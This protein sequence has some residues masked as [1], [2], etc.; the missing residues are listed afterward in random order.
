MLFWFTPNS[1]DDVSSQ[2]SC[3]LFFK[4]LILITCC[5]AV[6]ASKSKQDFQ[7]TFNFMSYGFLVNGPVLHYTYS[8]LI[9]LFAPGNSIGSV[10][11]KLLFTQTAFSLVSI[12]SF[13]I[14]TSQCEGKS[15]QG[16]KDEL[17]QKLL[18]TFKTNL[19][20]WPLL[21]LI[22]FTMVPAPLQVFYVNFMQIWWNAYLSFMKFSDKDH[23]SEASLE[24]SKSSLEIVAS[25]Q[26]NSEAHVRKI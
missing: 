2:S 23:L 26:I 10:A 21:Q 7:R 1:S 24:L 15:L 25:T 6:D 4:Y 20:V 14:F 5:T 13:F 9:P 19:K 3:S 8:K 16:T 11:K 22:N 17:C 12:S 18:P